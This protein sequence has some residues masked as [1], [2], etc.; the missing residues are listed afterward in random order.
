MWQA[1][2]PSGD[3]LGQNKL[4]PTNGAKAKQPPSTVSHEKTLFM[5]FCKVQNRDDSA[6]Y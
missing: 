5:H 4:E 1:D 6:A 3:V 2:S